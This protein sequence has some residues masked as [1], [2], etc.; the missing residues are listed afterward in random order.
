MAK[1]LGGKID[2][3]KDFKKG[4]KKKAQ[5]AYFWRV[6][7]DESLVVRFLTEPDEWITFFTYYDGS[8]F[9]IVTDETPSNVSK[10]TKYAANVV[11]VEEDKVVGLEMTK[12]L[13]QAV[14][15]I[16][17]KYGTLLDR[18]VE[19][20]REGSGKDDTVYS[21]LPEDPVKMTLSKYEPLDLWDMLEKQIDGVDEDDDDDDED[22][23]DEA[24]RRPAKK[25]VAKKPVRRLSKR[26]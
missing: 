14:S 12:T 15:K 19:L 6:K 16:Y 2:S 26:A 1:P 8:Q 7:A 24:P 9:H 10:S 21:A 13:A 25:T 3:I 5:G 23:E 22:D 18:D 4:L 17:E 11:V 20:T